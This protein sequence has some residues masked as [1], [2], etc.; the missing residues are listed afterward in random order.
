M[1]QKIHFGL[2]FGWG[3]LVLHLF[4]NFLMNIYWIESPKAAEIPQTIEIFHLSIL[5]INSLSKRRLL[6]HKIIKDG[7]PIFISLV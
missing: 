2:K 5:L 6:M 7:I 1:K 4:G 3:H